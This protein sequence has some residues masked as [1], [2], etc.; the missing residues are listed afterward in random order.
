[1]SSSSPPCPDT[2]RHSTAQP[3]RPL[4]TLRI[5]ST[6]RY[7]ISGS[8]HVPLNHV[9]THTHIHIH[10]YIH[11]CIHTRGICGIA[12]AHPPHRPSYPVA[13]AHDERPYGGHRGGTHAHEVMPP[14][15]VRLGPGHARTYMCCV[16]CC[17][18]RAASRLHLIHP[19]ALPA[20]AHASH[21]CWKR[22]KTNR[23]T[24]LS[25]SPQMRRDCQPCLSPGLHSSTSQAMSHLHRHRHRHRCAV[26][27]KRFH[28]RVNGWRPASCRAKA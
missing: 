10:A 23:A 14:A 8:F 5:N 3:S 24:S 1:M 25:L 26:T 19:G 9:L 27:A 12:G 6:S 20:Q 28:R 22:A 21:P 11:T 4:R 7:G 2:A 17:V 15:L 18:L 16:A 13:E